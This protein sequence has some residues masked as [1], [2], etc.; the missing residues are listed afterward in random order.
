M[1]GTFSI[2]TRLFS[3]GAVAL[4]MVSGCS[5]NLREE[6]PQ[7]LTVN[8]SMTGGTLTLTGAGLDSLI[9][10][11][12][13]PHQLMMGYYRT[14][15]DYVTDPVNYKTRMTDLP[16]SLDIVS[17]FTDYTPATNPYWDTLKLVYVPYLHARGTKVVYTGGYFAGASTNPTGLASWVSGIMTMINTYNY[18]GY[19][20]DIE[21]TATGTTLQDQIACF[22]ALSQYLG[23]LSG[24][25]KLLIYDTNQ[26][27]NALMSGIKNM[28]SYVFLQAYWRNVTSLQGTFNTYSSYITPSR[29]LVG[30]SYEDGTGYQA[31]Q[32][33]AYAAWQPTQGTKGG[34]FAYG[35]DME[36]PNSGRNYVTTNAAIQAMN[37]ASVY[38]Y[39]SAS[40]AGTM[41]LPLAK[42]TYTT[43]QLATAG[44]PDNWA[45][46]VKIPVGW[47]VI[48]YDN[49]NFAGT[50]WTLTASNSALSSLSPKAN[51]KMS[52]VKIQ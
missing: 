31:G 19:D 51:G 23:P 37:P 32:M 42:G 48:M 4:L 10:Y 7:S 25:G 49:D 3:L 41:S 46:S 8:K 12:N 18:D 35:I 1:P 11:K 16:D 21:S 34:V 20:I 45:S 38:F 44:V 9:A 36:G 33:P 13:S 24:T 52:S 28:V 17:V 40:Y 47:T 29:F 5:K 2:F 27:G 26:N 14:W 50:S 15:G 30:V 43:A 39:Q 6:K 22:Q